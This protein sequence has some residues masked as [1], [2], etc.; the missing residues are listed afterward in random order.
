MVREE[1]EVT[2]QQKGESKGSMQSD[3]EAQIPGERQVSACRFYLFFR[4]D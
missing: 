2:R 4:I 3:V 1:Q